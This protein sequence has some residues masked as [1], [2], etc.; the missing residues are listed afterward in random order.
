MD[1]NSETGSSSW[2]TVLPLQDQGFHLH[3][4]EFWDAL[5]LCYGWKLAGT[6]SHCVCGSPFS[7]DHAMICRHGGLTFV[8]R[9]KLRDITAEW[10]NKVCYDVAIKPPLQQLTGE[11][12]VPATANRQDEARADIHSGG[13]VK[14][15]FLMSGFSTPMHLVIATQPSRPS[16]DVTSKRRRGSMVIVSGKLRRPPLVGVWVGRRLFSVIDFLTYSP[17]RAI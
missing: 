9:N 10:L 15:P 16:I 3:K 1:L 2:L 4:Q 12:V 7:P 8:R 17:A 5:H 14:V 6:P 13:D 11:E